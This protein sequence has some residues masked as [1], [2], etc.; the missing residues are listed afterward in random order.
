METT[1]APQEDSGLYYSKMLLRQNPWLEELL[2]EGEAPVAISYRKPENLFGG[3]LLFIGCFVFLDTLLHLSAFGGAFPALAL[4]LAG[5][6][7]AYVGVWA[8]LFAKRSY[9][10]V[11]S[12][13][14]VYQK[15][16]LLGRPGRQISL[17]RSEI[18]RVRFLKSTVMYRINRSDGGISVA[19]KDGSTLLIP[20]VRDAETILGALR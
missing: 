7:A 2:K 14:L 16:N 18:Q 11:T 10:L 12:E 20:S 13:R 5:I 6:A 8:I 15:I 3:S 4:L 9:V 17:P 19:A 1:S